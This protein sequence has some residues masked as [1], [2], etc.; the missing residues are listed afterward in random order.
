SVTRRVR[1]IRGAFR[2]TFTLPPAIAKPAKATLTVTYAG[3][4]DTNSATAHS[5][6]R[7]R[8]R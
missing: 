7:I 1:I 8:S 4:A 5:A 2:L 6:L 3:D